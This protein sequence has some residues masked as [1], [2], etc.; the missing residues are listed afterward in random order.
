MHQT[1]RTG[2]AEAWRGTRSSVSPLSATS[3]HFMLST[4]ITLHTKMEN[5]RI[6]FCCL[7]EVTRQDKAWRSRDPTDLVRPNSGSEPLALQAEIFQVFCNESHPTISPKDVIVFPFPSR[8]V[9][10]PQLDAALC[11]TFLHLLCRAIPAPAPCLHSAKRSHVPSP[12]VKV[13]LYLADPA[14]PFRPGI[15]VRVHLGVPLSG[16]SDPCPCHRG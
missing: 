14:H 2:N 15:S 9:H 12:F 8:L 7:D 11:V 3:Q 4:W 10:I 1:Q 16:L 5:Q 6:L 13:L